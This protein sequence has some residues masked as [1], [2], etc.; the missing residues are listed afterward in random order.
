MENSRQRVVM[1]TLIITLF[2]I[3]AWFVLSLYLIKP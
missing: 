1:K 3:V 2:W